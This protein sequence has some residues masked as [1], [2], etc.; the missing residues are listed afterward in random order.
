MVSVD[1]QTL[2][3]SEPIG[4]DG[5]AG[6]LG[7]TDESLW[8]AMDGK[9]TVRVDPAARAVTAVVEVGP[10]D[11]APFMA[12]GDGAVWVPLTTATVARIDTATNTVTEILDLGRTGQTAGLGVGHESLWAGDCGH[13]TVLRIDPE[14][15]VACEPTSRPGRCRAACTSS[16]KTKGKERP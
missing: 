10:D 2:A 1:E 11:G 16:M 13:H 3:V 6:T 4:L 7:F 12:T 5:C 9:R 15:S 14:H 8:V